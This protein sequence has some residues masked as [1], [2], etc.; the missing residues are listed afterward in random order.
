LALATSMAA[1]LNATL[2][3]YGLFKRHIYT[4]QPGWTFLALQLLLALSAMGIVIRM[5]SPDLVAWFAMDVTERVV[6]LFGLIITSGLAYIATLFLSGLRTN[7]ILGRAI[8]E[9]DS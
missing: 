1:L 7:H 5:F 9:G 4:L 6:T 8:S 3:G 2:L